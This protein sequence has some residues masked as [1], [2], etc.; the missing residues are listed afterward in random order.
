MLPLH[1]LRTHPVAYVQRHIGRP[2]GARKR[3]PTCGGEGA[4]ESDARLRIAVQVAL[5]SALNHGQQLLVLVGPRPQSL[6]CRKRHIPLLDACQQLHR[7]VHLCSSST[8]S[9][10]QEMSKSVCLRGTQNQLEIRSEAASP[11]TS[12]VCCATAVVFPNNPLTVS[13]HCVR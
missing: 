7:D 9:A 1:Y 3:Q 10:R 13:S 5:D 12:I 4:V 2:I 6:R 11:Y 8:A